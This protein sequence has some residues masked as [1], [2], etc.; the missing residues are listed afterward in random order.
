MTNKQNNSNNSNNSKNSNNSNSLSYST[1]SNNLSGSRCFGNAGHVSNVSI[2]NTVKLLIVFSLLLFT[3][4]F[5]GCS[6]SPDDQSGAGGKVFR[7]GTTAYGP[8]M[9]NAGTDPHNSYDGWSAVRYGVGETL[10]KLDD[11][12]ELIPWLAD[13]HEQVDEYTVKV[14]I[15]DNAVFSNG[16]KVTGQAVKACLEDLIAKHDRAPADLK[17]SSITVEGQTVTITSS[18]KVPALLNYLADP[19][20]AIIDMEA[21]VKDRIVVGTGPYQAVKVSDTEMELRKNDHYWGDEKPKVDRIIV[22]SIPD[23][24]TLTMAMQS[25]EIDAAQGLPYSSLELFQ[26]ENKYKLSS[27]DTSRVYQV[28]FNEKSPALQDIRVREAI[29]MA[30]DKQSF[31]NTLLHGNGT[32]AAGPF[33]ATVSFGGEAVKA[34]PYDI[35]AA[36]KLLAE[37]GYTT[38][39]SEGYLEKNGQVL[40]LRWLTYTSRQELPLLAEAAQASLKQIGI[41]LMINAT[42]NYKSFLKQGDYDLFANAFVTAP[43]GDP[44]YYFA[45][46]VLDRSAYNAGFYHS[47]AMET[48]AERLRNTY[49]QKQ[50]AVLAVQMGQQILTD[51]AYLYVAHLKMVLVMK[52]TVT[53]FK[54]H[55][56][57]YYEITPALDISK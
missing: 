27:A 10:F 34:L 13:S 11:K 12:M 14:H 42:D 39:N 28:A 49:D 21:G 30:V 25:G 48:L 55:P 16:K 4:V 9:G 51:S 17:I 43:T 22:R 19:Y 38:E 40:E 44:A 2:P 57:D 1:N 20:G 15:R 37:A 53:G 3:F 52:K 5:S 24:D 32:P 36:R 7:Y 31:V 41:K 45:A 23:G 33:P 46:H 35:T 26:D 47:S 29:S 54:A 50:R 56:S 6:N 8:A 18:E